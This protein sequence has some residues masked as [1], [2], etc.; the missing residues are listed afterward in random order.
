MSPFPTQ[1]RL[2]VVVL[3][4]TVLIYHANTTACADA[5]DGVT[6]L[7]QMQMLMLVCILPLRL[8][9]LPRYNIMLDAPSRCLP[10]L[11]TRACDIEW[12]QL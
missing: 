1:Q 5:N 3:S 6:L 2:S 8:V 4:T 11:D 9:A 12:F 7:T 10:G